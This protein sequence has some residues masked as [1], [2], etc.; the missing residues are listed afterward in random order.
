LLIIRA[1]IDATRKI[2]R[3]FSKH[4]LDANTILFLRN[5]VYELL[6]RDTS[7]RGKEASVLLD[8]T[9]A[10]LLRELLRLRLIQ[11]DLK[12]TTKFMDIWQRICVSHVNGEESSQFLIE[13][14]LMRPRFLLNLVNHCKSYAINLNHTRIEEQDIEKGL[15]AFSTDL[16]TD[17]GYE[18]NDVAPDADDVLLAFIASPSRINEEAVQAK[19]SEFGVPQEHLEKIVNLLLWYG[20]LGIQLAGQ[21]AKY[22]H[23]FNYHLDLLNGFHRKNKDRASFAINPA[24]WPALIIEES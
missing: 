15:R 2:E 7:D 11:N 5:D 18:I 1:L 20:F 8:W 10:D 16:L 14:S 23:D 13:R 6:V 4:D 3:E 24:F 19:L 22:I 9:D 17:I 21:D 12:A